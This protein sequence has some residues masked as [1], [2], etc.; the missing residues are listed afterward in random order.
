M[1]NFSEIFLFN[2]YLYTTGWPA[3]SILF[4]GNYTVNRFEMQIGMIGPGTHGQQYG[5]HDEQKA[6]H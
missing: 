6:E 2:D 1:V 3:M 5:G 4:D